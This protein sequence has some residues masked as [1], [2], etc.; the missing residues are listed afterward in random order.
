MISPSEDL[1]ADD[2]LTLLARLRGVTSPILVGGQALNILARHYHVSSL[3]PLTSCDIDFLGDDDEAAVTAKAWQAKLFVPHMDDHTPNNAVLIVPRAGKKAITVDFLDTVAG[4]AFGGSA[5]FIELQHPDYPCTLRVLHPMACVQSR[6]WNIYGPLDRHNARELE[7]LRLSV[8]ILRQHL[9]E[10]VPNAVRQ[11]LSLVER[12]CRYTV[13][14]RLGKQAWHRDGIDLLEAIPADHPAWPPA[15]RER[16]WPDLQRHA[17]ES[18]DRSFPQTV[19]DEGPEPQ[20]GSDT[21]K[22]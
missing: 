8:R 20:K 6:L 14:S 22:P 5:T 7:R 17:Q 16:R 15:F 10:R 19:H 11:G 3:E 4:V 1:T 18:R 12:Y 13:L 9:A 21:D 2:V